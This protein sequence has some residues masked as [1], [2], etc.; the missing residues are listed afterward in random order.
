M[1]VNAGTPLGMKI[2]RTLALL[3]CRRIILVSDTHPHH[4]AAASSSTEDDT[5]TCA[6]AATKHAERSPDDTKSNAAIGR[7]T[8]FGTNGKC[9]A[10]LS[11][12]AARSHVLVAALASPYTNRGATVDEWSVDLGD[13][14][15]CKA[16]RSSLAASRVFVGHVVCVLPEER[17]ACGE[18]A[19]GILV[20]VA[21]L[22]PVFRELQSA[23][24]GGGAA[25]TLVT[26]V[27]AHRHARVQQA[28][29]ARL[30]GALSLGSGG[31]GVG[32]LGVDAGRWEDGYQRGIAGEI[33]GG[34]SR[35]MGR[36]VGNAAWR[37]VGLILTEAEGWAGVVVPVA[38]HVPVAKH[39]P[40]PADQVHDL[41]TSPQA[42][43]TKEA[44]TP[45][46]TEASITPATS[47]TGSSGSNTPYADRAAIL[48][49][50]SRRRRR[51]AAATEVRA[52]QAWDDLARALEAAYPGSVTG[53]MDIDELMLR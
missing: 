53:A 20:L 37:V 23:R 25:G 1:V 13:A 7:T 18:A 36:T 50:A 11:S 48:R 40:L 44:T 28:L 38:E 45:A 41:L 10:M 29:V 33:D 39:M 15:S 2:A 31:G 6:S 47:A 5:K 43:A 51:K 49:K 27:A 52:R 24:G 46:S 16:L 14:A 35:I 3:G 12:T 8:A 26:I 9:A 21:A 4:V 34:W 32:F 22:T 30:G 42:T 19:R 17:D